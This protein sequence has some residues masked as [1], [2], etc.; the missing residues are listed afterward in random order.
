MTAQVPFLNTE[1]FTSNVHARSETSHIKKKAQD[2]L[3]IQILL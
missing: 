1:L 2:A 3:N